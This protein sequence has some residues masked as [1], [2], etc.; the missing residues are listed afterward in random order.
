MQFWQMRQIGSG[1]KPNWKALALNAA[2][3]VGV[4]VY[5]LSYFFWTR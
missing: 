4:L 2:G 1:A 5:L 3:L